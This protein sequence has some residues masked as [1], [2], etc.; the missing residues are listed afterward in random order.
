[1]EH[2]MTYYV[3]NQTIFNPKELNTIKEG[4]FKYMVWH[5]IDI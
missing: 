5:A 2:V 3:I 1:M 4:I